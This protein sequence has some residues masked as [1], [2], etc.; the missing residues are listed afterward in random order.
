MDVTEII[1]NIIFSTCSMISFFYIYKKTQLWPALLAGALSYTELLFRTFMGQYPLVVQGLNLLVIPELFIM[2]YFLIYMYIDGFKWLTLLTIVLFSGYI[3]LLVI[4]HSFY[5]D[6]GL[7]FMLI[8]L[9]WTGQ[10]NR[11]CTINP[12][13]CK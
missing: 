4:G 2:I 3:L 6:T 8:L 9:V 11:P 12:W 10:S 1:I 13:E 7:I 5:G